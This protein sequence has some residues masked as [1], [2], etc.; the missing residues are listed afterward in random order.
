LLEI[1]REK[2]PEAQLDKINE[3]VKRNARKQAEKRNRV[4]KSKPKAEK[5]TEKAQTKKH[6]DDVI[7]AELKSECS[8][9]FRRTWVAASTKVRRRF[10]REVLKWEGGKPIAEDN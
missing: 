9:N 1:A 2:S 7:F 6:P 4:K 3:I 8:A 5:P 10:L